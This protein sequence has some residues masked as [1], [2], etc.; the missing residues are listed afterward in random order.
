MEDWKI[1]R[2]EDLGTLSELPIRNGHFLLESGYHSNLWLTL[3]D[4][5]V[6]AHKVAP[7]VGVLAERLGG[8]D[9]TAFCGPLRGG[10]FLA[11]ALATRL[12]KRFYYSVPR[13]IAGGAGLFKAEYEFPEALRAG[14]SRERVALV[15]DAMSAGSSVRATKIALD[16]IGAPTMVVAALLTLGSQGVDYFRGLGIPVEALERRTF[17]MWKPEDCPLCRTGN[18]LVDPR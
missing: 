12:G 3:D 10:A 18:P 1:G 11:H 8:Y 17:E 2:L 6:D 7:L 4:L 13:Q 5:F 15:D 9:V 14:L 16:A